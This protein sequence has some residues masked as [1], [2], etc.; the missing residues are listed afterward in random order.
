MT[1]RKA[2]EAQ[3]RHA[4]KME[5]IGSFSAAIAH[6]FNN[7]LAVIMTYTGLVHDDLPADDQHARDLSQV[8]DAATRAHGLT[9]QLLA[10]SR[11]QVLQPAVLQP[12]ELIRNLAKMMGRFLGEDVELQLDLASEV[13]QVLIDAGQRE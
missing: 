7:L 13:G 6:D 10:F 1:E 11:Q 5:A 3:L 12:N 8:L 9:R 4:Q 2:L